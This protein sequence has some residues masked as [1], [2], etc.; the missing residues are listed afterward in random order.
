MSVPVSNL[1]QIR[2]RAFKCSGI[3]FLI[4][5]LL[6]FSSNVHGQSAQQSSSHLMSIEVFRTNK[7]TVS[8]DDILSANSRINFASVEELGQSNTRDIYWIRLD[9]NG[10][11]EML[12]SNSEWYLRPPSSERSSLFYQDNGQVLGRPFGLL[13]PLNAHKKTIFSYDAYF[14]SDELFESLFLYMKVEMLAGSRNMSRFSIRLISKTLADSQVMARELA[15]QKNR[16]PAFLFVGIISIVFLFSITA[17]IIQRKREYLFYSFYLLSLALYLGRRAF[18]LHDAIFGS[19]P[20]WEYMTHMGLQVFINLFYVLFAKYFLNTAKDYPKLDKVI[21]VI[22]L[23]LTTFILTDFLLIY[24]DQ[25]GLHLIFMDAQR[26]VMA[27][28]GISASIYLLI[29]PKSRLVYFIVFGS[30][31]YTVGALAM[32]FLVNN[33]YMIIGSSIEIF[34]FTLGLGYKSQQLLLDNSRIQRDVLQ[35]KMSALRAQM[36]PHFI[37]NSL[38]SIQHLIRSGKESD[39]LSYLSKFSKLLRQILETSINI[40]VTLK[41]EIGLLKNYIE[42]ESLRFDGE[43]EYKIEVDPE[44][45]VENFEIPILL[46]QPYVENAIIHGLLPKDG[47]TS[48]QIHFT[49][50]PEHV[51][52]TIRDNGIGRAKSAEQNVKRNPEHRSRGLSLVEKRLNEMDSDSEPSILVEDLSLVSGEANGTKVTIWIPTE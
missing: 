24:T 2:L 37:F 18:N 11:E 3:L 27:A 4:S 44:V 12:A 47:N 49:Q 26:Y 41:E 52:C 32:L 42:L 28:F 14:E 38:G 33:T 20:L 13:A 45:D 16:R 48:L 34:V 43:F 29:K 40:Q 46:L 8:I 21:N 10:L 31:S 51:V 35:H 19:F 9:F 6:L 39:A 50:E 15:S 5:F 30:F 25:F 36:N 7:D 22:V 23:L 17:F 1:L